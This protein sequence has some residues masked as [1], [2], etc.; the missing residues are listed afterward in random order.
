MQKTSGQIDDLFPGTR[1]LHLTFNGF[2]T[3]HTKLG[4]TGYLSGSVAQPELQ[5]LACLCLN[6]RLHTMPLAWNMGWTQRKGSIGAM[7]G[8]P[9]LARVV[10]VARYEIMMMDGSSVRWGGLSL[11]PAA[12]MTSPFASIITSILHFPSTSSS[13]TCWRSVK[14]ELQDRKHPAFLQK[15]SV[16]FMGEC[17][18]ALAQHQASTKCSQGRCGEPISRRITRSHTTGFSWGHWLLMLSYCRICAIMFPQFTIICYRLLNA[19]WQ[20]WTCLDMYCIKL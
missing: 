1:S 11:P 12:W 9:V 14:D 16:G 13:F 8:L 6:P 2:Y 7:K 17:W 19:A 10:L 18:P 3:A 4:H 15:F 5:K 20:I